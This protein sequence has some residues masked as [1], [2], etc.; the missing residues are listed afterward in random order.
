MLSE[1]I[2]LFFWVLIIVIPTEGAPTTEWR[3]PL[4]F[5]PYRH[6]ILAM[7]KLSILV[8]V[9]VVLFAI[10]AHASNLASQIK[11]VE[12]AYQDAGGIKADFT[13]TTYLKMLEKTVNKHGKMYI[14]NGGKFR[15]EYK[16]GKNYVSNGQTLW[17]YTPG[18][19][20]SLTVFEVN[21]DTVPKEAMKFLSG[22]NNL[23]KDFRIKPSKEFTALSPG[24]SAFY[25]VPKS[26]KAHF[27][28][29]DAKFNS[30]NLLKELKVH[31]K[32]GNISTYRFSKIT[33]S[34][35]L[36]SSLFTH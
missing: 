18:D 19:P 2:D 6:I 9:A 15:L 27:N 20:G 21:S 7:K 1:G 35:N 11:A 8:L 5:S 33:T 31:N 29:L 36:P 30:D 25:L 26:G 34:K 17:V 14:E 24:E 22:F 4:L 12:T 10:N 16:G 13:Q 3:N 23:K 32:S 28:A